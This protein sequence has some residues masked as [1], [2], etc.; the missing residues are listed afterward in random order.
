MFVINFFKYVEYY[1]VHKYNTTN[2][3][4]IVANHHGLCLFTKNNVCGKQILKSNFG[5]SK[6]W[7]KCENL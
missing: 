6:K 4:G 5:L 1:E 7:G 3:H 2:K